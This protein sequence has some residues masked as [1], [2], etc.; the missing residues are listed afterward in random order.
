MKR[1][2]IFLLFSTS[3]IAQIPN[4]YY[5]SATGTGFA[6]KSQ[7]HII[8]KNYIPKSYNSLWSLY[9][10]SAYRDNYYE[11]DGSLLDIYSEKLTKLILPIIIL[12]Y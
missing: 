1:I 2:I 10:H 4:G 7:L 6:L 9:S 12:R 3:A 8:L 11:N 5:D